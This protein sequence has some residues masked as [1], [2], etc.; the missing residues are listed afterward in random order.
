MRCILKKAWKSKE[1]FCY[2][3]V[4]FT[5]GIR[6]LSKISTRRKIP[7]DILG[8]ARRYSEKCLLF[9]WNLFRISLI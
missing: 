4:S 8:Y 1:Q 2:A 9:L 3:Q 5:E 7:F 6:I